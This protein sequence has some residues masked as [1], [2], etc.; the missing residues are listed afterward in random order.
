MTD[1]KKTE[2]EKIL[3]QY[4]IPNIEEKE[5]PFLKLAKS[6][7]GFFAF[8]KELVRTN[9]SDFWIKLS[10]L[11]L[12]SQD[13]HKTEWTPQELANELHWLR[14]TPRKRIILQLSRSNWLIYT[15]G[16]YKLSKFAKNIL[17]T[18]AGLILQEEAND[19][20]G[21]NISSL[22]LIEMYQNDPTN[23][24]RTFLNELISVDNEIQ[25]TLESKSE[26]LI[27]KL[28]SKIRSQFDIAI[29]SRQHLENLEVD[30]FSTYRLKQKIH[31]KLS[32]FHSRLSQVQRV[33]NDLIA[34]KIILADSSL[35]Q[36]DINVFFIN[37]SLDKIASLGYKAISYPIKVMDLIPQ[38]MVY[39][40]EWQFEKEQIE[41]RK[42]GWCDVEVAQETNENLITHNHFFNFVGEINH[43]LARENEL[44]V[45][46]FI[47]YESWNFSSFRFCMISLLESGDVPKEITPELQTGYPKLKI[48]CIENNGRLEIATLNDSFTGVK[49]ITKGIIEIEEKN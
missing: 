13:K 38:L 24:L 46:K 1:I 32:A 11:L 49:E 22:T 25:A 28:N 5:L 14:E 27:T 2:D 8:F 35:T 6:Y 43:Q 10:I 7:T 12:I 45:E 17:S 41:D 15:D 19:A 33:Q 31:D 37:S 36:H 20:L 44:A 48:S 30:N 4:L 3:E 42:R 40:T 9:L 39:E 34:R 16:S 23:T 18:L 21:A 47:P 26:Y 29:K